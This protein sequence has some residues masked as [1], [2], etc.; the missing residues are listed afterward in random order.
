MI[1]E[2][3]A[4]FMMGFLGSMHC[5]GMCGGLVGALT[6]SRPTLWWSGLMSYQVGRV[7]TYSLLGL[8]AGL[9]GA[10]LHSMDWFEH[11]Q[12]IIIVLTGVMMVAFG[13]NLAGWLPDP[14]AKGASKVVAALGIG[15]LISSA[16][17]SDRP[18][19]WAVVGLVNGLLPCGLV[20]AALTFALASAGVLES[21][22]IMI[23]FGIGTIPAMTFV[24]VLVR[25]ITPNRRGL[26]LKV[27]AVLV[28]VL[29]VMMML[30]GT[31]WMR[32]MMHGGNHQMQG[33]EQPVG[34]GMMDHPPMQ[35]SNH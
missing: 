15:R 35:H 16:A 23:A 26:I 8:I 20:Y 12:R 34:S 17:A 29:G 11:I 6:M 10:G 32:Q 28:I 14:F 2:L 19:N 7:M 18:V 13:L 25:K 9:I 3:A 33:M 4:A 24:P 22:M 30:R 5:I 1:Y 31:D 27:A 21:G